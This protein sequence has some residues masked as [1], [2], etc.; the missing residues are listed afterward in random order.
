MLRQRGDRRVAGGLLQPDDV[1]FS[2]LVR[3]YGEAAPPQ[4]AAISAVLARMQQ[5]FGM[6]PGTGAPRPPNQTPQPFRAHWGNTCRVLSPWT[7]P[8]GGGMHGR[9]SQQPPPGSLFHPF[10]TNRTVEASGRASPRPLL[11]RATVSTAWPAAHHRDKLGGI[12]RSGLCV[13]AV[14]LREDE[15]RRQGL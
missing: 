11:A 7:E 15:G 8:R 1:A 5:Q 3:G 9:C 13:A 12:C 2:V 6:K 4:W 10:A 14:H